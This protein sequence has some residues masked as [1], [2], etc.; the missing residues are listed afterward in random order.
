MPTPTAD[1]S[2]LSTA[3]EELTRRLGAMAETA[4]SEKDEE[5]AT[6]LFAVERALRAAQRRL[7]KL[8]APGGRRR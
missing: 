7:S 8:A 2:S 1:L 6:E 5:T 4:A 3:L